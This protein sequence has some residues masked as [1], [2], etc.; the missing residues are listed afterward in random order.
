MLDWD[1]IWGKGRT[2]KETRILAQ[3][4]VVGGTDTGVRVNGGGGRRM[5]LGGGLKGGVGKKAAK[6]FTQKGEGGVGKVSPNQRKKGKYKETNRPSRGI[7]KIKGG[8]TSGSRRKRGL[9]RGGFKTSTKKKRKI[10]E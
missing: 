4:G 8:R 3:A 2:K 7:R 10:R 9:G 6:S 5:R 1:K